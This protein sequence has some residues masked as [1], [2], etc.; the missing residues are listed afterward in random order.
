MPNFKFPITCDPRGQFDRTRNNID[1]YLVEKQFRFS[2]SISSIVD[3]C[4]MISALAEPDGW[5][6]GLRLAKDLRAS[7]HYNP[8]LKVQVH[9][10]Y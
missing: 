10:S 3:G 4:E 5:V 6:N 2:V 7:N 9:V 8:S 1:I